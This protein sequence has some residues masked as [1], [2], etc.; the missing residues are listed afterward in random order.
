MTFWKILRVLTTDACNYRCPYCQ[1]EGQI[2]K[3]GNFLR[4]NDFIKIFDEIRKTPITEIRFSGGEPLTNPD[5]IKMIEYVYNNS[6]LEIGLATNASLITE[7]VAEK[8]AKLNVLVTVHLPAIESDVYE[9]ITGKSFESFKNAVQILKDKNVNFSFNHVLYPA[10]KKYLKEI[11]KSDFIRGRRLKLLPYLESDFKNLSQEIIFEVKK[12]LA[13]LSFSESS[14]QTANAIFFFASD[15]TRIKLIKSP[16]YTANLNSC[17]SYAEVRLLPNLEFQ[18]C[19]FDNRYYKIDMS[20]CNVVS[21]LSE[22]WA[23]FNRCY[24][25]FGSEKVFITQ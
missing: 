7:D 25:I 11:L 21:I 24:R 18:R 14:T 5:T 17:K 10:T 23:S 3:Q 2:K 4:L 13:E 19:I 15:D 9:F 6:E 1:N 12:I 16:C 22:M 20:D 8:L